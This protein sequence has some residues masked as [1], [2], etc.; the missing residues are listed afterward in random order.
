MDKR[1]FLKTGLLSATGIMIATKS[2]ALE[3][4]PRASDRKWAVIYST[5]C[6]STRDASL[7]ISEGM[8]GIANVFDV[9]EDPDPSRFDHIIVGGAI[10]SGKISPLMQEY[11]ERHREMLRSRL[12]PHS[13]L[14]RCRSYSKDNTSGIQPW[15]FKRT[16]LHPM[17][18]S[19]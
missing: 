16:M 11:L 12:I 15:M 14:S 8:D 19:S 1:T 18:V 9:R 6:G 17:V 7:W 10:R 5:W 3:Y 13:V 4:Y 2:R